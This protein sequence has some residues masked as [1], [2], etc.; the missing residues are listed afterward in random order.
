VV[1]VCEAFMGHLWRT[2]VAEIL[3]KSEHVGIE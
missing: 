3:H 1:T 2:Y